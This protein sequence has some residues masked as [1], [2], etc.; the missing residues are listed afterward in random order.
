MFNEPE[1][2]QIAVSIPHESS[3]QAVQSFHLILDQERISILPRV[4]LSMYTD[5][6]M[7][8]STH[9]LMVYTDFVMVVSTHPLMHP[10]EE[11]KKSGKKAST[12]RGA[13][14]RRQGKK[15]EKK[16]RSS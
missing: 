4:G 5:F 13:E 6:V 11:G 7:V 14:Q 9:P 15:T 12:S 2:R 1:L 8:V 3:V 16:R 10:T